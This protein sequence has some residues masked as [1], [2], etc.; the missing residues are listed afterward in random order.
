[1]CVQSMCAYE[2]YGHCLFCRVLH[3]C[4]YVLYMNQACAQSHYCWAMHVN[5]CVHVSG[6][7]S[8]KVNPC[9]YV[10]VSMHK[11]YANTITPVRQYNLC[12]C[13]SA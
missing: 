9:K 8:W 1:M 3:V 6:A 7:H 10:C 11:A 13:F 4:V 2:M 5:T 12:M